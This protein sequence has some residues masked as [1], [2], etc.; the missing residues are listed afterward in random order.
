M[1]NFKLEYLS[2]KAKLVLAGCVL[3][4]AGILT[5]C[6][7]HKAMSDSNSGLDYDNQATTTEAD[8]EA[9]TE[10]LL[11][12]EAATLTDASQKYYSEIDQ[13]EVDVINFIN[14]GLENGLFDYGEDGPTEDQVK[15]IAE[16]YLNYY[17]ML[18][19][20]DLSGNTLGVL[21]QDGDLNATKILESSLSSEVELYKQTIVS[22]EES[23]LNYGNIIQ[24][25][26]DKETVT[27]LA[28][29]VAKMHTAAY[30]NDKTTLD[31]CA[32]QVIAIKESLLDNNGKNV[33]SNQMVVDLML[34]LIDAADAL[35]NGGIIEAD[36]DLSQIYNSSYVAC[37]DEI[38]T[39]SDAKLTVLASELEID[40]YEAMSRDEILA[41]IQNVDNFN[42]SEQSLRSAARSMSKA[43]LAE[44]IETA[45]TFEYNEHYTYDEVVIR[46]VNG[47]DLTK[48]RQQESYIEVLNNNPNGANHYKEDAASAIGSTTTREVPES[49][50][51]ESARQEATTESKKY[52][53]DSEGNKT[54][55]KSVTDD[56]LQEYQRG[57]NDGDAAAVAAYPSTYSNPHNM[58]V[59]PK[60]NS[61]AYGE[62]YNEAWNA[63]RA[64]AIAAYDAAVRQEAT[65]SYESTTGSE[66]NIGETTETYSPTTE[67]TTESTTGNTYYVPV[68]GDEIIIDETTEDVR[69]SVKVKSKGRV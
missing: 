24:D 54:G 57:Y 1:K 8:T 30:A 15:D 43:I 52:E 11:N 13:A 23:V 7:I 36:E 34:N 67:S 3:V 64:S 46:I 65:T 48:Y 66:E 21:N 32:K 55:E 29:L 6:S 37:L 59:S 47:I 50:V 25:K 45:K 14:D 61:T 20:D 56:Y 33:S 5:G 22:E 49:E 51:P 10:N 35:Y 27:N 60:S 4:P 58:P 31:D 44:Q 19:K 26:T 69:G 62:G 28:T 9:T 40:G 68:D 41:Y 38:N 39:L 17:I 53:Y 12:D 42:T 2:V 16:Q 18:N 63:F